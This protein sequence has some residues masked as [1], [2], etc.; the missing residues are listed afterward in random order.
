MAAELSMPYREMFDRICKSIELSD[1]RNGRFFYCIDTDNVMDTTRGFRYENITPAYE[2]VLKHGISELKYPSE[3]LAF[4]K[5]YNSVCDSMIALCERIA[6]F[7]R[8]R[9]P[10]D[11][12]V[13]FFLAMI[14]KPADHFEEAIQRILFVNQLFWQTD[15]RL[16]GLGAADTYLMPYYAGDI[17]EGLITRDEALRI[18]EDLF[19]VLHENYE[20]KSNVLMG[21]TGQI[22]VL[23]RSNPKGDYLCNELTYLFIE[24]MKN[25]QQPDPKCLLRINKNTPDDLIRLALESISTGLGAPLLANDDIII[26]CLV[27]FGIP[28]EDACEYTTSACWEPLIGGK[29]ACNNNRTPLNYLRGLDNLLKRDNLETIR[30]FEDLVDR[31]LV[32]LGKNINAV[33][34]VLVNHVFQNDILLSVFTYGCF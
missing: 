11:P 7:L 17:Q 9:N 12:R 30:S 21:D 31:Y 20:Y 18:L 19:I 15:H 4:Q 5:D 33:K 6:E 23:G 13:E 27:K 32:Y 22:F 1:S 34:R 3:D 14:G 10:K 2:F 28:A 8:M 25:V 26:P 24:A 29:S 16:V